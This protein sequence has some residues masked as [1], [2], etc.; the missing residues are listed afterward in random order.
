M[1]KLLQRTALCGALLLPIL[2]L[3]TV[4]AADSTPAVRQADPNGSNTGNVSDVTAVKAGQPTFV[5]LAN[6]VGHN[7]VAINIVWTLLTGYLVMF[8]SA[9]F[10][11]V[12]TG[13][14]RA[15]NAAH[16]VCMNL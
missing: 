8:M 3:A 12:E 11:L 4:L 7:K 16:T 9:G 2:P 15:K 6:Q 14:T 13:F 5:E 1:Y 10:A